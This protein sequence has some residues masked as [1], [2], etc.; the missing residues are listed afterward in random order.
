MKFVTAMQALTL[1]AVNAITLPPVPLV[2]EVTTWKAECATNARL[3]AISAPLSQIVHHVLR[4][5]TSL[6][7]SA[8]NV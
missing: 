3:A 1:P 4:G 8:I 6:G 7:T 2:V 5:T